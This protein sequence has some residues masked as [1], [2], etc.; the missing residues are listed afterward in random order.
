MAGV[1]ISR[2][3]KVRFKETKLCKLSVQSS[4]KIAGVI[5]QI[6]V[7]TLPKRESLEYFGIGPGTLL[8]V[9]YKLPFLRRFDILPG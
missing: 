5:S 4:G 8:S 7:F 2:N 3:K 6:M 9:Q 1:T